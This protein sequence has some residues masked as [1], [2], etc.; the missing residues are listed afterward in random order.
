MVPPKQ[1]PMAATQ[2]A[3]LLGIAHQRPEPSHHLFALDRLTVAVVVQCEGGVTQTGQALGPV[4]GVLVE[5]GAF[6]AD[7]H[8]GSRTRQRVVDGEVT[9]HAIPV[10]RV[11]DVLNPHAPS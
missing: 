3:G 7:Q 11:L 9:H 8:A 4:L 10:D 2:L 6:V 1:K 5:P